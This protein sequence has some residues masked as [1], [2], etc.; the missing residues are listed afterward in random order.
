MKIENFN[1]YI[2]FFIKVKSNKNYKSSLCAFDFRLFY[3]IKGTVL[4]KTENGNYRLSSSDIITIP[5]ATQYKLDFE[6]ADAEYYI[7]NFDL[8]YDKEQKAART[9]IEPKAFNKAEV[10]SS[11]CTEPFSKVAVFMQI[12]AAELAFQKMLSLNLQDA[13]EQAF[14]SALMKTVLCGIALSKNKTPSLK[15][16]EIISEIKAYIK[17]NCNRNLENED[18]AKRFSYHP[19]YINSLF[20][21][22]TGMTLHKYIVNARLSYAKEMLSLSKKSVSEIA[23][24]CGFNDSSYFCA[25]FKKAS[26]ITPGQYR[27][28]IK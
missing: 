15:N 12:G 11:E 5:P 9:P 20:L 25:F 14:C 4:F 27:N 16:A 13:T 21:K 1:P 10:F 22:A 7:V 6:G 17:E 18:V 26:G 19:F 23:L 3:I 2:R 8:T 28:L 24:L